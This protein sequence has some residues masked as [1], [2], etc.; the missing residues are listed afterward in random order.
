M[1]RKSESME[2]CAGFSAG[3]TSFYAG[4]PSGEEW[5]DWKGNRV[6]LDT[7]RNPSAK[8]KVILLH[9]VGTNGRQM[10]MIIG[11]PLAKDG[12]EVIAIDMP[13]YGETA[14]NPKMTVSYDDW[15]T[16]GSDY[17]NYELTNDNRPIFLCGLSAGGMETYHV[18]CRNKKVKGIVGM[19]FLDQ[20]DQRVRDETTNNWFWARIGVPLA[21]VATRLGMGRMGMKISV[22]SKMSALCNNPA[23]LKVM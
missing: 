17:I 23:C 5:W 8:A 16:L 12:F 2:R 19:T 13:L 7:F 22:C 1:I 18:A 6:H 11:G 10:S 3:E 14:V 20:R 4:L 9:G 15:V 21:T